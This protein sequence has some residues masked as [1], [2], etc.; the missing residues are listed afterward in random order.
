MSPQQPN[1]LFCLAL[2]AHISYTDY[3]T[4]TPDNIV[5]EHLRHIRSRVDDLHEDVREVKLRLTHVEENLSMV[6]RRL[7][8]FDTRLERIERRLNLVDA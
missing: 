2:L 5:L 3:M 6:N 1:G 7:D 8:K 4:E